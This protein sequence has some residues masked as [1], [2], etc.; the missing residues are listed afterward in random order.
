MLLY[1]SAVLLLPAVHTI[2]R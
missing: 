1:F 2:I